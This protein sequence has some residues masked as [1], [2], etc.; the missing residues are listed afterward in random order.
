MNS[1]TTKPAATSRSRIRLQEG[2]LLIIVF[3]LGLFLTLFGGVVKLPRFE[4][5]SEGQRQRVFTTNSDGERVP[6]FEEKNK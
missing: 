4:I 5:G 2:G 6:Q 1:P 3:L